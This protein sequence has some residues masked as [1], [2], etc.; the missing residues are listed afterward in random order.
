MHPGEKVA[1]ATGIHASVVAPQDVRVLVTSVDELPKWNPKRTM[2]LFPAPDAV[3]LADVDLE[4]YDRLVV[5]DCTWNQT[6][7]VLLNPELQGLTKVK[8]RELETRFWRFQQLGLSYLATIEA[9][10]SFYRQYVDVR[11]ARLKEKGEP[12]EEETNYNSVDNLQFFF[13]NQWHLIQ[14]T[15]RAK[16]RQTFC[17]RH[18]LADTYIQR[19]D[20]ADAKGKDKDTAGDPAPDADKR[21][22]EEDKNAE[23]EEEEEEK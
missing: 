14:E 10:W 19:D 17:R 16:E 11:N 5:I 1:K 18:R 21:K 3:D 7:N 20:S 9:I 8:I 22:T 12:V 23:K 6:H 4:S 2:V 15:Y 13:A